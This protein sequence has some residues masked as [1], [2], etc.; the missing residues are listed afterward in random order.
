[1]SEE[2]VNIWKTFCQDLEK[3]NRLKQME[4]SALLE[5]TNAINNNY[6]IENLFKIF[7][8]TLLS[9]GVRKAIVYY[10][11]TEW[12]QLYSFGASD[13]K[14]YQIEA[15]R[16]L[17][18]FTKVTLLEPLALEHLRDFDAVIPVFHKE[19]PL[20]FVLLEKNDEIDGEPLKEK[21][22]FAQTITNIIIVAIENKRLFKRQ[23]Q[24]QNLQ[25]EMELASQVQNMLIPKKLPSNTRLDMSAIYKP[26]YNIGGDYYDYMPINEEEFFF[27]IADISGK[28]VAAALLMSNFQA[29]MRALIKVTPDLRDL[30]FKLNYQVEQITNGD[31]FITAFIGR[32][33][34]RTRDLEYVNAGHNPPVLFSRTEGV[35]LLHDGCIVLGAFEELPFIN[36]GRVFVEPESFL[37]AYTDGLT[38]L[39][40]DEGEFFEL[41]RVQQ[42]IQANHQLG[43]SQFNDKLQDTID[44]FRGSTSYVDDITILSMHLR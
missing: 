3:Q 44:Q 38:D 17:V 39:Q 9:I 23:L 20:A 11:W 5:I 19:I 7:E 4:I 25:K 26:H 30:V 36:Q 27:V 29:V 33:N 15:E 10:R 35:E 18:R 32:Y 12:A 34:Q 41:P 8:F 2:D 1:M 28:G 13:P 24:Q 16:D 37:M 40:N 22:K 31:K 14:S 42:F 43:M 21:L 6:S